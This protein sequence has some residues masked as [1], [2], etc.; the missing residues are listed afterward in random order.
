MGF[1]KT[2]PA[3]FIA[4]TCS[5]TLKK[6]GYK[7]Y[8]YFIDYPVFMIILKNTITQFEMTECG[9]FPQHKAVF[10]RLDGRFIKIFWLILIT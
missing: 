3:I 4:Q 6:D 9:E 10:F 7:I 5:K 8:I 1:Y 2:L